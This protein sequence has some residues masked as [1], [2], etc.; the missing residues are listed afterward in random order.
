MVIIT[1]YD[2]CM[3]LYEIS[4]GYRFIY[5]NKTTMMCLIGLFNAM[6]SY[7]MSNV[8]YLHYIRILK[9]VINITNIVAF[10][11]VQDV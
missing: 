6:F 10:K 1:S 4:S 2:C 5:G 3:N 9:S 7:Y 11:N 8:Y